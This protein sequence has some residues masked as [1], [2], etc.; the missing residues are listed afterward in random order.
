MVIF[1]LNREPQVIFNTQLISANRVLRI[2]NI[3]C[4]IT[5]SK[6][7]YRKNLYRKTPAAKREQETT[8]MFINHDDIFLIRR[9]SE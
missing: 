8:D 1:V 3:L 6:N 7:L 9:E 5:G 4:S 2:N